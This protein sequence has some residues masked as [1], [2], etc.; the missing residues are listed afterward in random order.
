[1]YKKIERFFADENGDMAE[2]AVV[3]A[4]IIIGAYVLWRGLGAR[5]GTL[6][7]DVTGAI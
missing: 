1:M 7:S 6:V 4:A 3:M 2:K 5:I